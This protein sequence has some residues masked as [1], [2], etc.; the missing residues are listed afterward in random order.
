[1]WGFNT[2]LV[3]EKVFI[4]DEIPDIVIPNIED[5]IEKA[6]IYPPEGEYKEIQPQ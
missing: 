4:T 3:I 5:H 1:M 2:D 6:K